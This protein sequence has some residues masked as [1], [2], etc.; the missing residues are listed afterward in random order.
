MLLNLL[1]GHWLTGLCEYPAYSSVLHCRVPRCVLTTQSQ[2][3]SCHL[4]FDLLYL[5]PPP[6]TFSSVGWPPHCCL[7]SSRLFLNFVLFVHLFI[8]FTSHIWVKP[9]GYFFSCLTYFA[10]HNTLKL[11]LYHHKWHYFTFS[12]G[13]E[14]FH[15]IAQWYSI[16][17]QIYFSKYLLESL[18]LLQM[19]CLKITEG[20]LPKATWNRP[21]WSRN[22]HAFPK[23]SAWG[24]GGKSAVKEHWLVINKRYI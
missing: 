11:H 5:L 16:W 2:V 9:F 23:E 19:K 8:C 3:F 20:D 21:I 15:C 6:S 24:G 14:V 13:W 1:W 22:Y 4:I 7:C 17:L 18:P 12:C 10:E